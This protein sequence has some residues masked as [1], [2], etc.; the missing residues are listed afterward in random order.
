[1]TWVVFALLAALG[2]AA[3]TLFIK[4][5][6]TLGDPLRSTVGF[7]I[8][9]GVLI[10]VVVTLA[11]AWRQPNPAY[12]RT[13]ALLMVPEVGGMVFMSLALRRGDVSHVQ[14]IFGLLPIFV[15]INGVLLVHDIP[16][17]L[18]AAGIVLV[19][20]GI[21]T[22]GLQRGR[23][24]LEPLVALGRDR[25]SWLAVLSGLFWSVTPFIH[26]M[27]SAAVG[28]LMW[29]MSVS[30]ISG[31]V[32]A[33]ILPLLRFRST[34]MLPGDRARWVGWMLATAIPFSV[35]QVMLQLALRRAQS[36]YVFAVTS[37][38]T[39]IATTLGV[40]LL[41]ERGAVTRLPG[42]VLVTAGAAL[43]ALGG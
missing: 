12:W 36:G 7:R 10:A 32:L 39:V 5:T 4:R 35:Q 33:L 23:S 15:T 21:Y 29:G 25:A 31:V 28:P 17:P 13:L 41:G 18:A 20:I 9:S 3:S 14:P 40:V 42:A 27:G 1:M 26:K 11:S 38:S 37:T 6:V 8:A 34:E 30:F 43:I 16:T 24:L 19:A 2:S 22:V